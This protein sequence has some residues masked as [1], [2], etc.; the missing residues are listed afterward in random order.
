MRD[1]ASYFDLILC[2]ILIMIG[3]FFTIA[4]LS[5]IEKKIDRIEK[6]NKI[7]LKKVR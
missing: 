5:K 7:I 6:Q 2:Y 1:H 3:F 4:T